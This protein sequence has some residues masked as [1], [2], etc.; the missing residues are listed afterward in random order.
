MM[1]LKRFRKLQ[2]QEIQ[3]SFGILKSNELLSVSGL[4]IP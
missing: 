3:N 4:F 2:N 1:F